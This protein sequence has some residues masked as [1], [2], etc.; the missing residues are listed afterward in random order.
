MIPS[1]QES[2]PNGAA[3]FEKLIEDAQKYHDLDFLNNQ[4]QQLSSS[5]PSTVSATSTD[6]DNSTLEGETPQK[7]RRNKRDK[8]YRGFAFCIH[9]KYG[10]LLLHCTRKK[11]KGPHYQVP[12]GHVDDNEFQKYA[13]TSRSWK[14][15]RYYAARAGCLR[16]LYE[17]TGINI[18]DPERLLPLALNESTSTYDKDDKKKNKEL[19]INEYKHRLFFV[20]T[21]TDQ[22]FYQ[23]VRT[24]AIEDQRSIHQSFAV[25][26][27][28][29][30][31][32]PKH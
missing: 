5:V 28:A 24:C 26:C 9:P 6:D 27:F 23:E 19:L 3:A 21:V 11:K 18:Q 8:D 4:E 1:D 10:M 7:Q 32:V 12:G 25:L 22:D 20:V 14:Q 15:Q 2:A 16:E 13:S 31:W 30:V 17:E 29:L